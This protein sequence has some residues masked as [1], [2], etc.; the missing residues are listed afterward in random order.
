MAVPK[1]NKV[2]N[3]SQSSLF[4]DILAEL[5]KARGKVSSSD[6]SDAIKK[7]ISARE[8]AKKREAAQ[9]ARQKEEAA[10][11]AR[12]EA[13]RKAEAERQAQEDHIQEVTSMD[14][15]MDWENLF[16]GDSRAEGVHADSI[17]AGLYMALPLK[18]LFM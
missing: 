9:Q 10:Q 5:Q 3:P 15:P 17:P 14:L 4:D 16:A 12:E 7:L 8:D 13:A 11:K 2:E 6:I 1:K 18:G